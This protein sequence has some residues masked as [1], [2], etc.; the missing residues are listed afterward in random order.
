MKQELVVLTPK[1]IVKRR[2][3][4][5]VASILDKVEVETIYQGVTF[6]LVVAKAPVGKKILVGEGISRKSAESFEEY[7]EIT[8]LNEAKARALEALD[9]K[10]RRQS[11][12]IGHKY[13]G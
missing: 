4:K 2:D 6:T 7:R 10:L 1:E 5:I 8:G 9:K 11:H 12:Y 3:L 13:E